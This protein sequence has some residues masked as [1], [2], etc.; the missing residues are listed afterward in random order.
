MNLPNGDFFKQPVVCNT[1][2]ILGLSRAGLCHLLAEIFPELLFPEAVVA[3]LR[4]KDAG[5]AEEISRAI[6][7]A[8]II[9]NSTPDAL[10]LTELDAGEAAVIQTA[11]DKNIA[12]VLMDERKGRR[13]AAT[14]YGLQV[15]GT[16]A[17]LIEAKR[18][19]LLREVRT[20][21][22]AMVAAGY[23]IGPRL[24]AECLARA[25]E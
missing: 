14:V 24:M 12:G 11:C 2:P 4:A 13:I 6:R 9:S 1:G 22:Y 20:P 10:L 25:G 23:F 19:N 15:R 16:C 7:P 8:R 18:R 17:V 3:E 5:D 21:L